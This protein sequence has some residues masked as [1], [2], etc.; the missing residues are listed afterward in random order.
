MLQ[1]RRTPEIEIKTDFFAEWYKECVVDWKT[2]LSSNKAS[3][4]A[5][6]VDTCYVRCQYK[7]TC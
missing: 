5:S 6:F 4:S 2:N 3:V 7:T 1:K